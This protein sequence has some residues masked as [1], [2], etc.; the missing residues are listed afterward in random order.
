MATVEGTIVAP[1]AVEL[2]GLPNP[3]TRLTPLQS[4]RVF[5]PLDSASASTRK[6]ARGITAPR[7]APA[8]ALS[9]AHLARLREHSITTVEEVLAL[10]HL[11]QRQGTSFVR[12]LKVPAKTVAGLRRAFAATEAGS[13][14]LQDWERFDLYQYTLGLEPPASDEQRGAADTG[15]SPLGAAG[16]SADV[17]AGDLTAL[18]FPTAPIPAVSAALAREC[19]QPV[20]DQQNRYTCTAF[21][22][23]AC[24]EHYLCTTQG[25]RVDL[26]EQFQY[27]NMVWNTGAHSLAVSFPQLRNTGV[28]REVTWPYFGQPIPGNDAQH[29]PPIAAPVEAAAYTCQE[30]LQLPA[31]SVD[32]IRAVL[33]QGRLVAVGIPV[34]L[35]WWN[36]PVVRKYGNITLPMLGETPETWGHA[37]ALVGFQADD[38][39][40]G[41][42]F[43]VVR[44]SWNGYWAPDS[45]LGPGYGTLPYAYIQ[46]L[47]WDAWCILR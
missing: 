5:D 35:S 41:G 19:L 8:A 36:S 12:N 13:A 47:N 10:D 22:S 44:N 4:P 40:A 21:A 3:K 16:A 20:R 17:E 9:D 37:V 23:V 15:A 25:L 38:D 2:V 42:G 18:G 28:C 27:W 30:V 26:S 46:R 39:F 6:M 1:G 32:A 45:A 29:P 31:N 43:F 14:E 24:L 11:D 33:M 7:A 34:Y